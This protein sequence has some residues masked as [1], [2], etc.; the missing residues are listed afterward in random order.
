[1]NY[2]SNHSNV[3]RADL[4]KTNSVGFV[5]IGGVICFVISNIIYKA[6]EINE[7]NKLTI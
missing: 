6:V 1:M 7:E 3:L 4:E 2:I 5:F